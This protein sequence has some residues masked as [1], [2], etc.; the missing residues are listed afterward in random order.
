MQGRNTLLKSTLIFGFFSGLN[1][2]L[3]ILLMPYLT[4][5]LTPED[6]GYLMVF[7]S[8]QVVFAAIIGA[9]THG[10]IFKRFFELPPDS[11]ALYLASCF[12]IVLKTFLL[13]LLPL[14]ILKFTTTEFL[15]LPTQWWLLACL[16]SPFQY[17]T[18]VLLTLFQAQNKP[19]NFGFFQTGQLLLNLVSTYILVSIANMGWAGRS[20]GIL[21]SIISSGVFAFIFL[22]Y[23]FRLKFRFSTEEYEKDA[24][25]YSLPIIPH[26]IGAMMI[27][28][29][30][31]FILLSL[32]GPS[33]TGI[34]SVGNQIAQT[35]L[36]AGDSFNKAFS[37]WL[38]RQLQ[39][40]SDEHKAEIVRFTYRVG[41]VFLILPILVFVAFIIGKSYVIPS[42]YFSLEASL[43]LQLLAWTFNALY[44][45]VCNYIFFS[46]QTRYLAIT[47]LFCGVINI[48]LCLTLIP[49]FQ[50]MGAAFS[51]MASY[52]LSFL[53]TWYFSNKVYPLPW[54]GKND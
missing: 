37:P 41:F 30:D 5:H 33:L 23:S 50:L 27:V 53:L 6:Y 28:M 10:A 35:I 52:L 2:G 4:R 7:S 9:S 25:N 31:R 1:A 8:V 39:N 42:T 14:T 12:R 17:A 11:L 43:P 51:F 26:S 15:G 21:F 32:L 40:P 24:L 47:T 13:V 38:F 34:Y 44:L 46:G 54:F 3:P 36:L 48:A 16:A 29:A 22:K 19:V 45:L 18:L 20:Y 49:S